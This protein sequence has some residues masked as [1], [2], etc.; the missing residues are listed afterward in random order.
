MV[1]IGCGLDSRFLRTDNGTV[2][3]Y[4]LDLPEVIDIKKQF[5][6]ETDRYHL[7]ASSVLDEGW[8]SVVSSHTGPFLFM[9]EGVFMYLEAE[10]VKSLVL[11]LQKRF[12]GS[13]LVCEMVNSIWVRKPLKTIVEHK[14]RRRLHLGKDAAFVPASATAGR[15]RSGTRGFSCSMTGPISIPERRNSAG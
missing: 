10:A 11:T 2:H 8:M 1:N 4:D 13:E 6:A 12:P 9:A 3:F 7:I 5:F 15:W 14:M